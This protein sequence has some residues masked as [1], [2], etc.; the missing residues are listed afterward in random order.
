MVGRLLR[1]MESE[2]FNS[3]HKKIDIQL[4]SISKKREEIEDEEVV[5]Q[6]ANDVCSLFVFL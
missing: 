6:N 1:E 2:W 3:G 5:M 4:S